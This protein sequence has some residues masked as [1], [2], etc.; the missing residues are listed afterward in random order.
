[1][2]FQGDGTMKHVRRRVFVP[3]LVLAAAGCGSVGYDGPGLFAYQDAC[4]DLTPQQQH[5]GIWNSLPC[6]PR[7]PYVL[8]GLAGPAGPGGI[9]GPAAP[10]GG[11]GPTGAVPAG[12]S[13]GAGGTSWTR[14]SAGASGSIR[15]G[16]TH[17]AA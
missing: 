6:Y 11:A 14:G 3:G 13:V 5:T 15:T 9:A 2:D 4:A 17:V 12:G 8:A 1:M 7:A 10:A 16:R